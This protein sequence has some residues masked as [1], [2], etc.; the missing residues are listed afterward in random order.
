MKHDGHDQDGVDKGIGVEDKSP[1]RL[2]VL[3]H[4]EKGSEKLDPEQKYEQQP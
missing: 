2:L 3:G 1:V 4:Q